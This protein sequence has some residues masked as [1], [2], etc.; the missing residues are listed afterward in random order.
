MCKCHRANAGSGNC[1][2]VLVAPQSPEERHPEEYCNCIIMRPGC[3]VL[4]DRGEE[5]RA[6]PRKLES[7]KFPSDFARVTRV[8]RVDSFEGTL[9]RTL[10]RQLQPYFATGCS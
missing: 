5:R 10:P 6:L 8:T 9:R 3:G 7:N 4:R 2:F 1:N